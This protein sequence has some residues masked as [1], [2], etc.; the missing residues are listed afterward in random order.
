MTRRAS[1]H[2]EEPS[3]SRA[4]VIDN[5]PPAPEPEA[6]PPPCERALNDAA[7]RSRDTERAETEIESFEE[8]EEE[9]ALDSDISQMTLRSTASTTIVTSHD[10]VKKFLRDQL[11]NLTGQMCNVECYVHGEQQMR[12]HPLS[13]A[14]ILRLYQDF[15]PNISPIHGLTGI[16]EEYGYTTIDGAG[17]FFLNEIHDDGTRNNL[18]FAT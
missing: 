15:A 5:R 8:G 13:L 1:P 16:E 2:P 12:G 6:N 9:A 3:G 11:H 4:R 18:D 10:D 14:T 7:S 17:R